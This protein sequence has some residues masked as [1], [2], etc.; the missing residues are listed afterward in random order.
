MDQGE[1]ELA[2]QDGHLDDEQRPGEKHVVASRD[3]ISV[4]NA[5][6]DGDND[7]AQPQQ[8]GRGRED[9]LAEPLPPHRGRWP[10][11]RPV[12]GP[13]QSELV[14]S[15]HELL[16]VNRFAVL[17]LVPGSGEVEGAPV[18]QAA[19]QSRTVGGEDAVGVHLR[20]ANDDLIA[21]GIKREVM[22][23]KGPT[24]GQHAYAPFV[25]T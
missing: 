7:Q 6:D 16:D 2:D 8:L 21:L 12:A 23:E 17:I 3:I 14:Q 11:R 13:H 4:Q 5:A 24:I 1:R 18:L 20:S 10:S 22:E 9:S 15:G 25:T 19:Q